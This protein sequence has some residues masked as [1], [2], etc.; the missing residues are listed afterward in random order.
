MSI[1]GSFCCEWMGRRGRGWGDEGCGF[2]GVWGEVGRGG[3]I[4]FGG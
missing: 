4:C 2:G 3:L 1:E